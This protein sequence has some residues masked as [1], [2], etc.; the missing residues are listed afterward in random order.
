MST[1]TATELLPDRKERF[2]LSLS[3][4]GALAILLLGIL[5]FERFKAMATVWWFDTN[6][7]HGFLIIPIS[8]GLAYFNLRKLKTPLQGNTM[9]G[10]TLMALGVAGLLATTIYRPMIL[11]FAVVALLLFGA[12]VMIGGKPWAKAVAFPI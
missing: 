11:E 12:A 7:S 4:L 1:P 9:I 10:G 6:Y 3:A 5:F 8:A 2:P